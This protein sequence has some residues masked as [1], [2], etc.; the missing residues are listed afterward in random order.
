MSPTSDHAA[1]SSVARPAAGRA[2]LGYAAAVV[3]PVLLLLLRLA[4]WPLLPGFPFL[5]FVPAVALASLL[6][7]IGPGL[8]AAALSSPL[9]L[10][11]LMDQPG[12]LPRDREAWAGLAVFWLV[13]GA[14]V[15][16]IHREARANA[17]AMGA[18][19]AAAAARENGLRAR[20]EAAQ[21]AAA[22]TEAERRLELVVD[23]L[24]VLVSQV[25]ADGR[26]VFVNRAYEDWFGRGRED[27]RGRHLEEVLG[28]DLFPR[29][30]P[31]LEAVLSGTPVAFEEPAVNALGERREM[32]GQYV[33]NIGPSGEVLGYVALIQDVTEARR[34][35]DLLAQRE[36][37]LRAVLDSVTDCF[38]AVDREWRITLVNR[39]AERYFGRS[40]EELLGRKLWD[41]F[42]A[43]LGSEYERQQKRVMEERVPVTFEARSVVFPD[44]YI[45]MRVS[46]K[47]G[48]GIAVSFSDITCRKA[49]ER[50]R[51]LLVHEL[52]H[53][54]K[55]TL[56]V[57]QSLAAQSLRSAQVPRETSAAFE[58]RL[59]ALAAAHD[60]L[61][62]E[63]WEAA[64]LRA[65]V[66]EA[67]RPFDQGH[68]FDI[69]GPDLRIRPQAAVSLTLALHELATNASKYGALSNAAGRVA[70]DWTITEAEP[71]TIR[72]V[73]R[74]S[75]GPPVAPPARRGFGSRLIRQGLAGE[76]GGTV[77]LDFP[78]E[79]LVCAFEA[80]VAN[81]EAR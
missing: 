69:S 13:S 41:A 52:N 35:S 16:L 31:R 36:R 74:E 28:P 26:F 73:W 42:P 5:T 17:Q 3:L 37:H 58:G 19:A 50:Q 33:P 46:P 49:Q 61:T 70:V 63:S 48:S 23:A 71:R 1:T 30:K 80:P 29:M 22:R 54:V 39:A 10:G 9:A 68:R 57:V 15:L 11:G 34:Q 14:V 8:L 32:R 56:A 20:L 72:F 43:H 12:F 44:R 40:A 25:D 45:E 79:G 38:Y 81:L 62:R 60:L 65:V 18:A 75:G 76:V 51:E 64:E 2:P 77:T 59:M 47:E 21:L 66:G 7:G 67:L 24:P 6:G 53:R 27:L 4:L 78:P 55:N